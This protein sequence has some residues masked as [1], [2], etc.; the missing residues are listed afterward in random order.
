MWFVISHH[1]TI[2]FG[3]TALWK[4]LQATSELDYEISCVTGERGLQLC[5]NVIEIFNNTVNI[6]GVTRGAM[7]DN[8]K[9]L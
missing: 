1:W 2:F 9:D 7:T 3:V 4:N 5:Q 6:C 8:L